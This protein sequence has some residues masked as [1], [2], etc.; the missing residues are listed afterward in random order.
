MIFI[1]Q[2]NESVP[3]GFKHKKRQITT[4]TMLT[5]ILTHKF[6]VWSVFSNSGWTVLDLGQD[7]Q[8]LLQHPCPLVVFSYHVLLLIM[9]VPRLNKISWVVLS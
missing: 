9:F 7:N 1:P 6:L 4:T 5:G 3:N 8:I 2:K